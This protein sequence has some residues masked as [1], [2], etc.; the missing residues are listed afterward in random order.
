MATP[1]NLV[2]P[3]IRLIK[4]IN[5]FMGT[6]HNRLNATT[7]YLLSDIIIRYGQ[8]F[9]QFPLTDAQITN[10]LS[11]GARRGVFF[12]NYDPQTLNAFYYN[13][14]SMAAYNPLNSIF[15]IELNGGT[16]IGRI[17][18]DKNIGF[19]AAAGADPYAVAP[20]TGG[21]GTPFVSGTGSGSFTAA[22]LSCFKCVFQE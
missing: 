20:S 14:P 4:T 19:E 12:V 11:G 7:G 5:T 9:P 16:D 8:Q 10:V 18:P 21:I 15:V 17:C 2:Q 13:N 22:G 6:G 3:T 1:R